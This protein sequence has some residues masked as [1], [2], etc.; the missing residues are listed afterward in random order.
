MNRKVSD[1]FIRNLSLY[2]DNELPQE[3]MIEIEELLKIDKEV[4]EIFDSLKKT[5]L[6]LRN[7]PR[8]KRRRNFTLSPEHVKQVKRESGWMNGM[9]LVS[10]FSMILLLVVFTQN[11]L[12]DWSPLNNIYLSSNNSAEDSFAMENMEFEVQ[13]AADEKA[14]DVGDETITDDFAELD[15]VASGVGEA[16]VEDCDVDEICVDPTL[17]NDADDDLE[18]GERAASPEDILG[19]GEDIPTDEA[20]SE[21]D[22]DIAED[23]VDAEMDQSDSIDDAEKT[24]DADTSVEEA[25]EIEVV[26]QDDA[27][28]A[29]VEFEGEIDESKSPMLLIVLALITALSSGT[30]LLLRKKYS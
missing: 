6:V 15:E 22:L 29:E 25:E 19:E 23:A 4:S 10:S 1:K 30:Y 3:E 26:G 14:A 16:D 20:D 12:G 11:L 17:T 9:R 28:G 13:D 8:I 18:E 2:L 27:E 21:E 7:A 24:T 5:R